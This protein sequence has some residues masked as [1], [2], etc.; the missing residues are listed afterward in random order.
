MLPVLR[1]TTFDNENL[2]RMS[3]GD[4]LDAIQATDSDP[5][6]MTIRCH[7]EWAAIAWCVNQG[8]D[9]H[10][11]IITDANEEFCNNGTC[12]VTPANLCVLLR[13]LSEM[14]DEVL[15]ADPSRIA[16]QDP[17]A[18]LDAA[19]SLLGGILLVLGFDES[20]HYVGREALGLE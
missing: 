13:R 1:E 8:I 9:S 3:Y 11:E 10:L 7:D 6:S 20:G 18:V 5:F 12:R 2:C 16:N 17:E 15:K 14:G 4:V 19:S